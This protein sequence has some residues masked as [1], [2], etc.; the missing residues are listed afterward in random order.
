MK[1]AD[2]QDNSRAAHYLA[3]RK[4][5]RTATAAK[6]WALAERDAQRAA[7]ALAAYDAARADLAARWADLGQIEPKRYSPE[8]QALAAAREA[9]SKASATAA[10]LRRY[11]PGNLKPEA[12]GGH[13]DGR[14]YYLIREDGRGAFRSVTPAHDCEGGPDHNGWYTNPH[15]ESARD[16]SGLCWGIVAQ[17]AGK[18]RAPR[19]LAGYQ[20]GGVDSGA[21][22]ALGRI[23][24]CPRDAARAADGLAESA[25][26]TEKEYQEA[27]GAGNRWADLGEE[28]ATA[29]REALA[30]L[31][32]RREAMRAAAGAAMPALCGAI[33]AQVSGLLDS[34]REAREEREELAGGYYDAA[35]RA[36]FCEGAGLQEMPA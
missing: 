12:P 18:D 9:V 4:E 15:G 14:S 33:R 29:R 24:D 30:I 7:D 34:I 13:C 21:Q 28:V 6:A 25:A 32:E 2:I 19:Y 16:G 35:G 22:V 5:S 1:P 31:K 17:L 11:V 23:Y 36:A 20:F 10:R 3:W 26:E 27:W 8:G